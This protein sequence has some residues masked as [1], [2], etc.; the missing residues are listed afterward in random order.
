MTPAEH[1]GNS[2]MF[3]TTVSEQ[4]GPAAFSVTLQSDFSGMNDF[5]THVCLHKV[6]SIVLLL[7]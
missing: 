1:E 5:G 7:L 6:I 4:D 3:I 2:S